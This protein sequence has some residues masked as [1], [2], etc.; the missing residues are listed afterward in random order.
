MSV[1]DGFNDKEV[2]VMA[3][4]V[5]EIRL[6]P[7]RRVP[8]TDEQHSEAVE[9]LAQLLFDAA[10]RRAFEEGGASVGV[11]AGASSGV[12]PVVAA[13]GDQAA[14]PHQ[15]RRSGDSNKPTYKEE[16]V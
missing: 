15:R 10:R 9:L 4:K 2:L 12:T 11:P 1:V 14:T 3:R 7:P 6:L 13:D 5:D 8:M 16:D